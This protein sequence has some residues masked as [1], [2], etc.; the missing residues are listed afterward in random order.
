LEF[1]HKAGVVH[2]D[3]K[4]SNLL[5]DQDGRIKIL[6]MGLAR[7]EQPSNPVPTDFSLTDSGTV[8]GTID[9]MSPEQA[10]NTKN[11]DARSDVYSLGC[12]LYYLITGKSVFSGETI[13][14]RVLAHREHPI[15]SLR[16]AQPQIPID[17][18]VVFRKMLAK[19]PEVRYQSMT[20]VIGAL[21]R[22]IAPASPPTPPPSSTTVLD[23]DAMA[24]LLDE[25]ALEFLKNNPDDPTAR[26]KITRQKKASLKT[27]RSAEQETRKPTEEPTKESKD[28][29]KDQTKSAQR[30]EER[31]ES[32]LKS[33]VP[34]ILAIV[35]AIVVVALTGIELL[36]RQSVR[37]SGSPPVVTGK[38][39][40]Q[41][42]DPGKSPPPPGEPVAR[43][44]QTDADAP[45]AEQGSR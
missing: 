39:G 43:P 10:L 14:E 4:P 2:R 44:N 45:N 31:S 34:F 3:I 12:S 21:E 20:D 37:S 32:S 30:D 26:L 23:D 7:I 38:A 13:M 19:K 41:A 35:A 36:R 5:L 28:N 18:D 27:S 33:L 22:S 29:R 42:A 9:Y 1:A 40:N 16:A 11:A 24:F 8:I 25:E 15:P 6:D 17:L